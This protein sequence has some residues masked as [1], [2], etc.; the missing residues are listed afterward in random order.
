MLVKYAST[1]IIFGELFLPVFA[2]SPC[3][4][5]EKKVGELQRRILLAQE[6]GDTTGGTSH[7]IPQA[8]VLL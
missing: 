3:I 8:K 6:R 1:I 4:N 7:Q 2:K 5:K